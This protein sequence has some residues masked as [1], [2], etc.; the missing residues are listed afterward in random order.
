MLTISDGV[1]R[2]SDGRTPRVAVAVNDGWEIMEVGE[3]VSLCVATED[4]ARRWCERGEITGEIRA[5]R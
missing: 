4:D 5:T 1:M 3:L 2:W